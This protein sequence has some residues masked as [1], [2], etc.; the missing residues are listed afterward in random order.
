MYC[1]F[2]CSHVISLYAL[3]LV[4]TDTTVLAQSSDD[5]ELGVGGIVGISVGAVFLAVF[6]IIGI[7]ALICIY[8][9][10]EQR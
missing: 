2:C 10:K 1:T 9:R 4:Y 5:N 6:A 8:R 7:M 3:V